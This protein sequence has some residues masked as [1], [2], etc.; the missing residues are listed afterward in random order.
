MTDKDCFTANFGKNVLLRRVEFG[1]NTTGNV[2]IY[3]P[4]A[5]HFGDIYSPLVQ[6]LFV[7]NYCLFP[8]KSWVPTIYSPLNKGPLPNFGGP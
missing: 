5:W 1:S 8:L 4:L 7:C 2:Y 6:G 3:S